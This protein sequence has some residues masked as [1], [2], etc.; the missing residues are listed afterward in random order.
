MVYENKD[1]WIG[2]LGFRIMC[3]VGVTGLHAGAY[4]R[5]IVL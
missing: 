2:L 5:E 3:P 4:F 1:D